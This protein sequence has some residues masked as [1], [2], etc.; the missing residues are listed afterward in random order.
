MMAST[1]FEFGALPGEERVGRARR[2]GPRS[3]KV[4]DMGEKLRSTGKQDAKLEVPSGRK[5]RASPVSIWRMPP[6]C[7]RPRRKI[8]DQR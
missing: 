1:T 5:W 6:F 7:N 4:D 3:I 8:D 2:A